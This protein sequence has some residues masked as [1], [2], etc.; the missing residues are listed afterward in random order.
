MSSESVNILIVEDE[1]IVAEDLKRTLESL[2]YHVSG[3]ISSGEQVLQSIDKLDPNL[4][5]M[6]IRLSKEMDGIEA[7][8]LVKENYNIPIIFLTA[9]A[10][11][12]TLERAKKTSPYGYIIKPFN[13]R[14]LHSVIEMAVYKNM[15]EIELKNYYNK[16]MKAMSDTIKAIARTVE[17]RDPYTAGHQKRVSDLAKRI[18]E[19]MKLP[20]DLI[21]GV[22][23]AANIHDFGKIS[24]PAEILS[25]PS[26]LSATEFELIK[27]HPVTGYEI[28][29]D[30]DFPWPVAKIVYQHHERNDGSGYP[31]GLKKE[32]ILLEAKILSVS[33]VVES[34]ASHR[35]YRASL[36]IDSALKEIEINKG[37]HF[38]PEVVDCCIRIFRDLGYSLLEN[39]YN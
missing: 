23:M 8:E 28:L 35:P 38:D 25:K 6:D 34:M 4:I 2:Q 24:V 11:D 20:Q 22:F 32:K 14:E 29:K 7:A 30:I 3:I 1:L 9:H 16:L 36:G 26:K 19:E 31:Q 37:N 33:D 5:M 15:T 27:R 10:E 17:S 21:D 13:T 12:D 18:A 39:G